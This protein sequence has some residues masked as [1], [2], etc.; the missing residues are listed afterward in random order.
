MCTPE[1]GAEEEGERAKDEEG[2][3]TPITKVFRTGQTR[4]A[5]RSTALSLTTC[6]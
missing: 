3:G 5:S 1:K 6:C 4:A 2:V